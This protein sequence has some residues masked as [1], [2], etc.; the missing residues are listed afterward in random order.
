MKSHIE[1][2]SSQILYKSRSPSSDLNHYHFDSTVNKN[3]ARF[4]E[5]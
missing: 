5:T 2:A 3:T 1:H 4:Q